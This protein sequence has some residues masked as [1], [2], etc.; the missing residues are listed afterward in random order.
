[1]W[2]GEV[3]NGASEAL[4]KHM[5]GAGAVVARNARLAPVAVVTSRAVR[6]GQVGVQGGYRGGCACRVGVS[7]RGL[8]TW[9]SRRLH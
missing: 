6:K 7:H 2:C 3:G 5:T 8:S 1:M 9:L 4:G